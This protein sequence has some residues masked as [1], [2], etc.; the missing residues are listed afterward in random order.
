MSLTTTVVVT[1]YDAEL[2]YPMH[3]KVNYEIRSIHVY[4]IHKYAIKV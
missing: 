2:K 1:K 4:I 3:L